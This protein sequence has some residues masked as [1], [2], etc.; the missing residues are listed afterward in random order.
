[1]ENSYPSSFSSEWITVK[2]PFSET[3]NGIGLRGRRKPASTTCSPTDNCSL[4][5]SDCI[6][7][8]STMNEKA[9]CSH[10]IGNFPIMKCFQRTVTYFVAANLIDNN[11]YYNF[12]CPFDSNQKVI[13]RLG[14]YVMVLL[15]LFLILKLWDYHTTFISLDFPLPMP[16][17]ISNEI[18][19]LTQTTN[20]TPKCNEKSTCE[21]RA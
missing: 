2:R 14:Y 5:L 21:I 20:V 6:L 10:C 7:F 15:W 4:T 18:P 11:G 9:H 12:T 19:V 8:R 17:V 3:E 13:S 1:M 16:F